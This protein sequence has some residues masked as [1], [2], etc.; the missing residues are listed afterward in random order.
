MIVSPHST[1]GGKSLSQNISIRTYVD[2]PSKHDTVHHCAAEFEARG[3][4]EVK[5]KVCLVTGA[6]NGIGFATARSLASEGA[7]VL[8]HG[9]DAARGQRAVDDIVRVTDNPQVSFVQADFAALA[10]VRR[11][12]DELNANL[13]RL[14]VLINNAGLLSSGR[15]LTSDGYETTFAVNHLAPFLLTN[16]LLE[17]LKKSA[18][19]RIVVVASRAHRRASLDF[20][21]LMSDR[22]L[23]FMQVYGRSKL[24]NILFTRALAKRLDGTGVTVNA[25]HPGVVSTGLF[26]GSSTIVR[27]LAGTIGRLFMISPQE[28]AKTSVYLASSAEVAGTSG[29]YYSDC[30]PAQP[31]AEAM[32]DADAE[33]LWSISAKLVGLPLR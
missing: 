29:G 20:D 25:L 28:G 14:D 11:L 4:A 30:R 22:S 26:Q 27:A 6:T 21:D 17:K 3:N 18:P 16:L 9:R 13:P 15:T 1:A 8:V 5:G 23:K 12:A 32:S 2:S 33:R 31:T 19:A 24:A 7:T 10:D